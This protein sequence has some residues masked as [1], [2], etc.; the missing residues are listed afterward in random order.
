MRMLTGEGYRIIVISN[1]AGI[2]RGAMTEADLALIHDKMTAEA[3]A[4]GARIDAI[5]YCPHDWDEGCDCRKPRPGMLHQAQR[6]WHLDLT[7]T[8]FIGDD[9]RDGEAAE[10]VGCPFELVTD[11]R[12]LLDIVR[13]QI[14]A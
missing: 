8:L 3:E 6:D 5:Y 1:Q 12:S 10:A 7:R 9:E 14:P 2:N 11:Q 13:E 4:A